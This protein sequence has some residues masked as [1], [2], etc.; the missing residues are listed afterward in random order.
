MLSVE[1]GIL[2]AWP[3]DI[4]SNARDFGTPSKLDVDVISK[5]GNVVQTESILLAMLFLSPI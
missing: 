1:V 4:M 5:G 2:D 3:D